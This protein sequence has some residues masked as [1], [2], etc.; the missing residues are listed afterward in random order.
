MNKFNLKALAGIIGGL[1]LGLLLVVAVSAQTTS[2]PS[3]GTSTGGQTTTQSSNG[4]V[5][6]DLYLQKLVDNLGVS[7]DKLTGAMTQARKDT[8][9]QAVKDGK[10]TQAQADK[11]NSAMQQRQDNGFVGLGHMDKGKLAQLRETG[12]QVF[13]A[14]ADKLG[15]TTDQLKS[16][17]KSGQTLADIAKSKNVSDQDL[18]TAVVNTVKPKLDQ[19]VKDGKITQDQ[20]NKVLD[21]IQKADLSKGLGQFRHHK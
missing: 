7:K 12:Q 5:Y 4:K 8:L 21:R 11:V 2:T 14:V 9:A 19:A 17:L 6:R 13:Q 15:M 3:N 18:K 16:D 20:A 1:V 10:I